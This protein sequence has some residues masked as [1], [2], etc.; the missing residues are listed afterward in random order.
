MGNHSE[1]NKR[2]AKNTMMLYFRM[3]LSMVVGFYVSRVVLEALGARDFGIYSAVGGVVAIFTFLNTSMSGSTSRFLTFEIGKK[4]TEKLKRTFSSALSIHILIALTIFVLGE[5]IG[6]W[7]LENKLTIPEERM[8][9]ARVVYQMSLV[10]SMISIIRVPYNASIIAHE[11][12]KIYAYVEIVNV[13]LNL[14]IAYLLLKS[15][16]DKLILYASL[17]LCISLIM[18]LFYRAYCVRNFEECRFRWGWDKTIAKPMLTFSGWDLYGNLST[19][20]RTQGVNIL[21]N[22]F[23][24]PLINAASAVASQVQISVL[25][26]ATNVITAV[27]PQIVKSY[28]SGDYQHMKQLI[29]NAT[30]YVYLLLLILS[31]P[32]IL[33]TEFALNL[34]LIDVPEYTPIFC[35]YTLIFN[36]FGTMSMI[37]VSGI[38]ATGKIKR[39]SLINGTLYL[40]VIPISYIAFKFDGVPEIP[41]ICNVL[42]VFIGMLSNVYTLHL[43]VPGFSVKEFIV[44]VLSIC[45][46][47][48][49]IAVIVSLLVQRSMSDGLLRFISVALSSGATILLLTYFIAIDRQTRHSINNKI[50]NFFKKKQ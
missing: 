11:R 5:T 25:G 32:I 12:M 21:L 37:V 13:F 34:W 50:C 16:V 29:L 24:G 22:M 8:D 43:Y 42:A 26:F 17:I 7:L 23:F 6:L 38:H 15:D 36:F 1:D 44:R 46:F 40:L 45:I 35:R 10:V 48:T 20:A 49:L 39:P 19:M 18:G 27:R 3:L 30:K 41:Y 2:I 28:A 31:L 4:D 9:S 14:G 33:E 47:I